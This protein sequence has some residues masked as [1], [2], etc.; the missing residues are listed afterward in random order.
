LGKLTYTT[1]NSLDG[2]VA[3]EE[4]SFDWAQP[5]ADVHSFINELQRPIG[6]NGDRKWRSMKR[7]VVVPEELRH[8]WSSELED[9]FNA[10]YETAMHQWPVPYDDLFVSTSFGNTH[11]VASGPLDADLVVLL[12]PGGGS[13]T[14]W[15]G[16]VES[17]CGPTPAP[18]DAS[19]AASRR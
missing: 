11:P 19:P 1:I 16:R 9:E 10:A 3:D 8:F 2:F 6:W 13:A 12:N 7:K 17:R 15:S 4:D 5:D 18:P 14:I